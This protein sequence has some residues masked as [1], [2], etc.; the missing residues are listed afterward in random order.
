M[1]DNEKSRGQIGRNPI[2]QIADN[3]ARAILEYVSPRAVTIDP[4]G[5]VFVES[6]ASACECDMVG[7]FQ[8]D[9]GL[10]ELSR[11]I[12][13]DLKHEAG[14]RGID[15]GRRNRF[16]R[17]GVFVKNGKASTATLRQAVRL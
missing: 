13:D 5:R 14:V 8:R 1:S 10:L 4:H 16:A 11:R 6:V 15:P 17:G 2:S 12:Y 3:C 9:L 7:A